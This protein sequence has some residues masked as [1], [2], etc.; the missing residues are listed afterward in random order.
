MYIYTIPL[1][2]SYILTYFGHKTLFSPNLMIII[3]NYQ[4]YKDLKLYEITKF[5]I[6]SSAYYQMLSPLWKVRVIIM[7]ELQ[8]RATGTIFIVET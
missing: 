4:F 8:M 3:T 5:H 1:R 6:G 7:H 2:N